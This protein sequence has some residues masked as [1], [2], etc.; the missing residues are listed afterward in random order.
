MSQMND[1]FNQTRTDERDNEL[2]SLRTLCQAQ[3]EE[4]DKLKLQLATLNFVL[5]DRKGEAI[6]ESKLN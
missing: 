3:K 4:I 5:D 1:T 2:D 6:A